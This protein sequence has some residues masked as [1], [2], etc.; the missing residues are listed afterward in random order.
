MRNY[1]LPVVFFVTMLFGVTA[2]SEDDSDE[3]LLPP[4]EDVVSGSWVEQGNQLV[5]SKKYSESGQSF[6]MKWTSTFDDQDICTSSKCV[7][8]CSSNALANALYEE[9][10]GGGYSV[11]RSGKDVTVDFSGLY[12]GLSKEAVKLAIQLVDE[13]LK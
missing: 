10:K 9:L 6:V 11:T 5:Y 7:Y 12:G 3:G 13:S 8:S 4:T 1:F 2:C